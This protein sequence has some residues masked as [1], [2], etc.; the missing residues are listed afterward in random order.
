MVILSILLTL[1]IANV[2]SKRHYNKALYCHNKLNRPYASSEI[3]QKRFLVPS[4]VLTPAP[5]PPEEE[6]LETLASAESNFG[7][8]T[9]VLSWRPTQSEKRNHHQPYRTKQRKL[10]LGSN[11]IGCLR[12]PGNC[13]G[14][15][16]Q[17][18]HIRQ[19]TE[20]QHKKSHAQTLVWLHFP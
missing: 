9:P 18:F 10:A 6:N 2:Q 7:L 1:F 20:K 11:R 17:A 19:V 12:L 13:L 16:P 4:S 15:Y 8:Q 5:G 14:E 3:S